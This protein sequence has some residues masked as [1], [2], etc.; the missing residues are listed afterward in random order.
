MKGTG[1]RTYTLKKLRCVF[2][3]AWP[4]PLASECFPERD[5]Y[6][7][8]GMRGCDCQALR[9]EV[10][11]TGGDKCVLSIAKIAVTPK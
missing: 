7:A 1:I 8:G 9:R 10:M 3:S 6:R 4:L 2:L 11:T 5:D